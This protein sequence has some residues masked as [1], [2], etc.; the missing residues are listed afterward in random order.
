MDQQKPK[1]KET[2]F[3]A[4]TMTK[5]LSWQPLGEIACLLQLP[6]PR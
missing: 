3:I 2:Q 5:G 6:R 4:K 1:D